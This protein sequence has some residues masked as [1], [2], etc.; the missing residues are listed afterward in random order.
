VPTTLADSTVLIT[1]GTGSFGATFARRLLGLGPAQVRIFSRDEVKQDRMRRELADSRVRFYIGDVRDPNS[2][3]DALAGTDFVFHAAAL[4][5]VP[6]CE[7]FPLEAVRTNVI[8][9]HNVIE[10]AHRAGVHTV[11]CLSTDKAV[12][13]INA[14]GMTKGLMEK[15]AQSFARNHPESVTT[16][17][18]VRYGNVMY[19]RGSV[20][21]LLFE[22]IT[23]GKPVTVTD[24]LMTRFM[25]TLSDSVELVE[26]AFADGA[27][28]DLFIKKAAACTVG[29][30]VAALGNLLGIVPSIKVIGV[31]HGEKLAETLATREELV[32]SESWDDYFRIPLDA[33]ALDYDLYYEKGELDERRVDDYDSNSARQLT[34]AEVEALIMTIPEFRRDL[35]RVARDPALVAD[36]S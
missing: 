27:P 20:I 21:P 31:R 6:S 32:R 35:A 25:M 8:G 2:L 4:K 23:A 15:I 36:T 30:L 17:C 22:Q 16:V 13:P 5:Q 33:R 28:G 10:A 3:E 34:T 7:F 24:P 19:S 12:Y 1:G 14:M 9:S 26:R 11:V 29:T 18:S